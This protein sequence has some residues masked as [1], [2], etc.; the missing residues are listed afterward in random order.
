[1]RPNVRKELTIAWSVLAGSFVLSWLLWMIF[2]ADAEQKRRLERE[3][4]AYERREGGADVS[5]A[6]QLRLQEEANEA[7]E[8]TIDHLKARVGVDVLPAFTV[9]Q[10]YQDNRTFYFEK[11]YLASRH[12]LNEQAVRRRVPNYAAN[13]GFEGKLG[14]NLDEVRVD[15]ELVR[16]QL[17]AKAVLLALSTDE[18]LDA[19]AV[20]H[21]EIDATGP[22]GRPILLNEYAFTLRVRGGLKQILWLVHQLGVEEPEE[23]IARAWDVLMRRIRQDAQLDLS[24]ADDGAHFPLA[25]RR[26]RISS[27]NRNPSDEI[28]QLEAEIELAGMAFL[29]AGERAEAGTAESRSRSRGRDTRSSRGRRR[30]RR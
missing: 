5:L 16:L 30:S 10:R 21:G 8:D 3:Q 29:D 12:I 25:V 27:A 11:V 22:E 1:M 15:D 6:Q 7:L 13:L 28:Q 2:G 17:I 26:L 20:E 19:I 14:G 4:T 23:D 24:P 9:P 18:T